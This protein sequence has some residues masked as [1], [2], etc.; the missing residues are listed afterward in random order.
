MKTNS[1]LLCLGMFLMVGAAAH[2]QQLPPL[3]QFQ[4]NTPAR[5]ADVNANFE[6]LRG[7][8]NSHEDRINT[9][10]TLVTQAVSTTAA[11]TFAGLTTTGA[12]HVP[13]IRT[14]ANITL[15]ESHHAVVL[16][17]AV[18][19][20]L[21]KCAPSN[22]G[23]VYMIRAVGATSTLDTTGGDALVGGAS[24]TVSNPKMVVSDGINIW[25]VF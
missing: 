12:V 2:A 18:T 3:P 19:V 10:E 15:D 17:G 23:R 6:T 11:P 1:R 14:S 5:A 20:T 22:I 16:D 8:A 21:P 25:Y 4:P 9:L 24:V 7:K 13:F